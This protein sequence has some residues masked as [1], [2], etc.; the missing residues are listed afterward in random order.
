[1]TA[2]NAKKAK[3]TPYT[4]FDIF[5]DPTLVYSDVARGEGARVVSAWKHLPTMD[6][7]FLADLERRDEACSQ[8]NDMVSSDLN[9]HPTGVLA[10]APA[11]L[12]LRPLHRT[13]LAVWRRVAVGGLGRLPADF[14]QS[15]GESSERL[16][17]G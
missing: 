17:C 10:V 8:L 5:S 1:M 3:Y 2:A 6:R 11:R 16:W 4:S 13:L 15:Q 9:Y 12:D 14:L 7:E